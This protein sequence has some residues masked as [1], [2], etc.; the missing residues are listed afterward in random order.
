MSDFRALDVDQYDEE[1]LRPTDLVVDDQRSSQELL[2]I[3]QGKQNGVR[4]RLAR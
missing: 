1:A 2:S 4:S 3:A